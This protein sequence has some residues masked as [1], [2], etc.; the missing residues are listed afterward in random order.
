MSTK[1]IF[2]QFNKEICSNCDN[3]ECQEELRI[4]IDGSIKCDKYLR[5]PKGALI[6]VMRI[7]D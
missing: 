5:K 4:K 2:K 6:R 7:G 1:N 3:K